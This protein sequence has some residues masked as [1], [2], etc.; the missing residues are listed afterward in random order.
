MF[1][2]D[3][4]DINTLQLSENIISVE[5]QVIVRN[6]EIVYLEENLDTGNSNILISNNEK[7]V[8]V[9]FKCKLEEAPLVARL[10]ADN[11]YKII[12]EKI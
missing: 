8:D 6:L 10:T 11:K 3:Y 12:F 5:G 4:I 1:L 2:K 7:S 9:Y